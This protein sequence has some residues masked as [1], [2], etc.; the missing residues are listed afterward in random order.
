MNAKAPKIFSA[1]PIIMFIDA[2]KV[3]NLAGKLKLEPITLTFSRFK[4]WVQNQDN[5]WRTWGYMEKVKQPMFSPGEV[6][7]ITTK[8]RL[9][10][11]RDTYS[12]FRREA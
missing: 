7:I 2:M 9:Q 3:D 6:P 1:W 4:R 8:Q 5:A 11:Y 12:I 10:E